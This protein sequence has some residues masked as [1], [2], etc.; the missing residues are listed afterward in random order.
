MKL[1]ATISCLLLAV[2]LWA[3][4]VCGAVNSSLGL[5]TIASWNRHSIGLT[6]QYR[7]YQSNHPALFNE[8]P[9]SSREQFQRI[10]VSGNIRL[11]D[12]WQLKTVVPFVWNMQEKEGDRQTRTGIADPTV[13]LHYFIVDRQDSLSNRQ[14]R[15]SAGLGGKLPVASFPEPHDEVLLLYPGTG[16]WDGMAQ[17]SF[18][19]RLGNWGI[20]QE[21]NVLLRST[22]KYDYTPGNLFNA[23]LFGLHRW[24]NW[25]V[26]GGFQYAWNGIDYL[27]RS[28]INSSPAQGNILSASLGATI[29]WSNILIQANAHVPVAQSLGN[30]YTRQQTGFT[31]GI[32]YIFN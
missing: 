8:A 15:W 2:R 5:G 18:F 21:T 26:F 19:C 4:D 16:T 20:I 27:N 32:H 31:A 25:S 1:S 7:L 29:Q 9:V 13:S 28:A 3:C 24:S 30:G 23:T 14:F 6:Y 10:D 22:N 11:G 17:S 12:R